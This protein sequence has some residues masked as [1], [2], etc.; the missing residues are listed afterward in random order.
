MPGLHSVGFIIKN[1]SSNKIEEIRGINDRIALLNIR[2]HSYKDKEETGT[3]IRAQS[4]I[5]CVNKEKDIKTDTFYENL[6]STIQAAL[7]N[8]IVIADF[9]D[10]KK[11]REKEKNTR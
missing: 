9:N 7:K 6:Q 3:V 10:E 4:S 8:L 1:N 2:L 5:K 11:S